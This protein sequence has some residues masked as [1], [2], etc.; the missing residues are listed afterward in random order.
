[1]G[2]LLIHK[3]NMDGATMNDSAQATQLLNS[4]EEN[5]SLTLVPI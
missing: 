1:M 5:T 2:Q 4:V 3:N